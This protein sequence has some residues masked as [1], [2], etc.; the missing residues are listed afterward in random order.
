MPSPFGGH[1]ASSSLIGGR[2]RP[3]GRPR[4]LFETRRFRW[5]RPLMDYFPHQREIKGCMIGKCREMVY[6]TVARG[7]GRQFSRVRKGSKGCQR[8]RSLG[9]ISGFFSPL[10]HVFV[11]ISAVQEG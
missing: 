9:L 11:V 10:M 7:A 8:A 5:R 1:L 4:G 6:G 2:L 3:R